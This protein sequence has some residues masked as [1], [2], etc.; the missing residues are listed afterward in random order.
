MQD[1]AH[2]LEISNDDVEA[3]IRRLDE[4]RLG[5]DAR[6]DAGPRAEGAPPS[7]RPARRAI[8]VRRGPGMRRRAAALPSMGLP[9]HLSAEAQPVATTTSEGEPSSLVPRY[10]EG[11]VQARFSRCG[12]LFVCVCPTR[13]AVAARPFCAQ[14]G[15][16]TRRRA[17]LS[18]GDGLLARPRGGS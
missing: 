5:M 8:C 17:A 3:A 9:T 1:I 15:E 12:S 11:L 7:Y 10:V 16:A 6:Q 4:L 18:A 13:C 14:P 2:I